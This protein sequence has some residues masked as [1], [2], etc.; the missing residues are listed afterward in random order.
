MLDALA[1]CS[2][3]AFDKTGTLTTGMLAC[4]AMHPLHNTHKPAAA[5][6]LSSPTQGKKLC[7]GLDGKKTLLLSMC[8]PA[9]AHT[10]RK[11]SIQELCR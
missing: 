8:E 2:T 1:S 3:I 6:L 9:L 7:S 11:R 5:D 4:T 10:C